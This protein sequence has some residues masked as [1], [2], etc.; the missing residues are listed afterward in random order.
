MTFVTA[1]TYFE[2]KDGKLK[3]ALREDDVALQTKRAH[4][5]GRI[6]YQHMS[7]SPLHHRVNTKHGTTQHK[8][9]TLSVVIWYVSVQAFIRGTVPPAF[10]RRHIS[11]FAMAR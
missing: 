6:S 10:T 3:E 7:T 2:A 11:L 9:H 4:S 1:C 5:A 8:M